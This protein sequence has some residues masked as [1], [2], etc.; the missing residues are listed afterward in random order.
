M[1]LLDRLCYIDDTTPRPAA[2]NMALDEALLSH[3]QQ[4]GLAVL[5]GYRW[6]TRSISMGYFS[7]YRDVA[8]R[9]PGWELV[10]RWTGGGVVEHEADFTYSLILPAGTGSSF[11]N[12]FIYRAVNGA[13]GSALRASGVPV[14]QATAPDPVVSDACFSRAVVADLKWGERKVAGAAIRRHR[15]GVLLQGSVQRIL[16]PPALLERFA[17]HLAASVSRGVVDPE[18][19]QACERLASQK[20]GLAAWTERC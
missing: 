12:G 5:R 18:L 14:D 13:L 1:L 20:Y 6:R 9:Y 15:L 7:R 3:V 2:L 4:T 17:R 19:L 11:S 8:D 16:I 10:R